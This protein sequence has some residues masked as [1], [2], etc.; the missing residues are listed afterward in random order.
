MGGNDGT[1]KRETWFVVHAY[2]LVVEVVLRAN[3]AE[4]TRA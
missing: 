3:L 2:D 4:Y 1:Q